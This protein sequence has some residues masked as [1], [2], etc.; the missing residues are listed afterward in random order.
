MELERIRPTVLR[1]TFHAYEL[2]ALTAAARY[3][4]ESAPADVPAESLDQLEQLLTE[5]DRQVRKLAGRQP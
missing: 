4:V 1:G 3:V 5:Y 2:A